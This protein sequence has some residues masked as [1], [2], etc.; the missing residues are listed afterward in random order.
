MS[1]KVT[2]EDKKKEVWQGK[3]EFD[4]YWEDRSV[5]NEMEKRNFIVKSVCPKLFPMTLVKLGLLLTLIGGVGLD[6][7]EQSPDSAPSAPQDY[8]PASSDK[9]SEQG[10]ANLKWN[11]LKDDGGTTKQARAREGRLKTRAN[12]HLLM[13]G[14]PGTGKSQLMR[15]GSSLISRCVMATGVGSTAAGLTCSAVREKGA[16]AMWTLEAGALLLAD[17]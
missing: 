5:D 12:S 3:Q 15:F 11:A 7:E 1:I 8:S 4:E 10:I 16:D 13:I 9:K 17:R 6:V 14:D 2:N